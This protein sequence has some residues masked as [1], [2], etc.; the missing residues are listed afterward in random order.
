MVTKGLALLLSYNIEPYIDLWYF[1]ESINGLHIQ[2]SGGVLKKVQS[3]KNMKV[4]RWLPLTT[5][6]TKLGYY[7][8]RLSVQVAPRAA[9]QLK[10]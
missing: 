8:H 2:M 5:T 10:S 3:W 7:H 4:V 9:K 6:E 1:C